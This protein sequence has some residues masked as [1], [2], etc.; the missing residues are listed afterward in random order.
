[1]IY[2]TAAEIHSGHDRQA[3][4]EGLILQLPQRHE[5]RNSWLLNYGRGEEARALRRL[6]ELPFHAA[7]QAVNPPAEEGA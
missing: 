3:W 6:R 5:G 4:A 2:A 7:S 1:V